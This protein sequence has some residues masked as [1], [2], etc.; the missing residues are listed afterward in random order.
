M[1][2]DCTRMVGR[3]KEK[4]GKAHW[5]CALV[6]L[7]VWGACF[8]ARPCCPDSA[9]PWEA[10]TR[11]TPATSSLPQMLLA[12]IFR[13][14]FLLRCHAD[15]GWR[16]STTCSRSPP[17]PKKKQTKEQN[18]LPYKGN[19]GIVLCVFGVL[20]KLYRYPERPIPLN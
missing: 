4:E 15:L 9:V 14:V 10:R 3:A 6:E 8:R 19:T 17:P 5:H 7:S 11:A 1:S 16:V 18:N 2:R 12:T 13:H 20:I